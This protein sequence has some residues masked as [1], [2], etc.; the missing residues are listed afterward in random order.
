VVPALLASPI[1]QND[2][3]A[4]MEAGRAELAAGRF[5]AAERDLR[6]F[7]DWNPF[8]EQGW[9]LLASALNGAG[10]PDDAA[11]ALANA[12]L[13]RKNAVRRFHQFALRAEILGARPA[14]VD[15]LRKALELD[16]GYE[17]ARRDLER[18]NA[19]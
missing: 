9:K 7:V 13:A 16:P 18:L 19:P 12:D 2:P 6:R 5:E 3:K 11:A 10:R 8:S 15:Y 1:V 17:A 14:A 4:F